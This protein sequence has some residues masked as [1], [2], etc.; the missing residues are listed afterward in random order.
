[1]SDGAYKRRVDEIEKELRITVDEINIINAKRQQLSA[2]KALLDRLLKKLN[3][4]VGLAKVDLEVTLLH[5]HLSNHLDKLKGKIAETRPDDALKRKH[6]LTQE[7]ILLD[8]GRKVAITL[9]GRVAR[10]Q[11]SKNGSAS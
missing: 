7:R 4:F 1:M 10:D 9:M 3:D 2:Q 5:L 6:G 8:A 11:E